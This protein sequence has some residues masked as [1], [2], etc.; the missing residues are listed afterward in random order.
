MNIE[1]VRELCLRMPFA[2][3]SMP[4]GDGFLVF[5]VGGKMFALLSLLPS[6]RIINL[7]AAPSEVLRLQ[8]E[9]AA[10]VPAYHM[11]KRHWVS[12]HFEEAMAQD[13]AHWVA[14]SYG[15][16]R[17][18]LPLKIRKILDLENP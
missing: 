11:N 3:E 7:K 5:K 4:F 1:E 14:Q 17:G 8:E 12:V 9:Y 16:V 13:L 2:E 15:L 18:K 10:V 6:K